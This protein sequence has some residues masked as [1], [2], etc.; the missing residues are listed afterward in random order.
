MPCEVNWELTKM[1]ETRKRKVYTREFKAKVGLEAIRG[2]KTASW[3][4]SAPR[5]TF[6]PHAL[7]GLPLAPWSAPLFVFL[8]LFTGRRESV[9]IETGFKKLLTRIP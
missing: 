6:L 5:L 7:L 9:F 8:T 1:S 2:V 3:C 4:R